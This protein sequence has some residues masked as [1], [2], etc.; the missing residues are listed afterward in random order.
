M[1][2][3][4]LSPPPGHLPEQPAFNRSSKYQRPARRVLSWWA[5]LL[6]LLIGTG[7]GLFYAWNVNPVQEVE[8]RPAQLRESDKAHYAVAIALGFRYD[9]D[10]AL[11]IRRLSALELGPDPL[12]AVADIAC[13][14]ASGG[15]ISN[16]PGL[17][18]VRAMRTFYQLQGRAGCADTLISAPDEIP[19]EVTIDVPTPTPS[20]PPPPTKTPVSVEASPTPSG[21]VIVP[22]SAPQRQ[23]EG[24]VSSTFCDVELSGL[25]EVYVLESVGQEGVPG[26]PI[27]VQWEGGSSLFFSGLKP[28]R[29]AAYADFQME[30]GRSYILAMPGLSDPLPNPLVA[31]RCITEG[32]D[33]AITS[34]R[35]T[36]RRV[37]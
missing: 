17:Q 19:L 34:Y 16:T 13:D 15:Y 18:A 11:A 4:P 21:V 7:G 24:R 14:L 33:E 26:E 12:Q 35:V 1:S 37:E 28:E 9:S 2:K 25:I 36:F 8:T 20:M 23:Y 29:G 32:G 5:L 10:L 6:G 31:D 3:P 30:A 22:T 27:R